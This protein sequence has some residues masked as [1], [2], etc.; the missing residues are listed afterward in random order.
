MARFL[1]DVEIRGGSLIVKERG[2]LAPPHDSQLRVRI[3]PEDDT[4]AIF[5]ADGKQA[6]RL[7]SRTAVLEVGGKASEGD[8]GRREGKEGDIHLYDAPR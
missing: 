8:V 3:R 4:V 1:E 2:E 7:N 5:D 6:L